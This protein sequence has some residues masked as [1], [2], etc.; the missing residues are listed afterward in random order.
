MN[1]KTLK[2]M[3][4]GKE[5]GYNVTLNICLNTSSNRRKIEME[6][7]QNET[8]MQI[9]WDVKNAKQFLHLPNSTEANTPYAISSSK[10]DQRWWS[11]Q[12]S[13]TK[14][15]TYDGIVRFKYFEH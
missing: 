2:C 11:N 5:D 10:G 12:T 13:C 3:R 15:T 6:C 7:T 14:I 8:G 1:A 9:W 4:R